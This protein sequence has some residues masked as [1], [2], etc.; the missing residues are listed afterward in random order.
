MFKKTDDLIL[1]IAKLIFLVW[2]IT[3]LFITFNSFVNLV[4][5][6]PVETYKYYENNNCKKIDKEVCKNNYTY[7]LNY[8]KEVNNESKK[9]LINSSIN[10]TIVSIVLYKLNKE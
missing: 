5:K 7:Q 6:E 9:S 10:L 2:T 3:S 4:V 1:K 8:I